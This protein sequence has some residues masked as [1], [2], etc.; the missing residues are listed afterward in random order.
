MTRGRVPPALLLCPG[1]RQFVQPS[2]KRCP[3]CAGLMNAMQA[4]ASAHAVA[5][6]RLLAR[7]ERLAAKVART[8]NQLLQGLSK[9]Q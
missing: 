2:A 8:S 7:V 5:H 6:R 3:H 9:T 4:K 1:C